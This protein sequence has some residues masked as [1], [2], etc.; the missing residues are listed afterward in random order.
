MLLEEAW[1]LKSVL[2]GFFFAWLAVM[3]HRPI[4]FTPGSL[5]VIGSFGFMRC[6]SDP[7]NTGE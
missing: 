4:F 7:C 6:G 3:S 5:P 1:P 2:W